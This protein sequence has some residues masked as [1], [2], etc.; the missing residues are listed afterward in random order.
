[1]LTRGTYLIDVR[2]LDAGGSVIDFASMSLRVESEQRIADVTTDADRYRRGETIR[3]TVSIDGTLTR[4]QRVMISVNDMWGRQVHVADAERRKDERFEFRIPVNDPLS[5]LWDVHACI[6]DE[7]G[8]VDR[9]TTPV[10]ILNN[11]FDDF[12]FMLIFAPTPGRSNWKGALHARQLRKYGINAAYVYLIYGQHELYFHN[13]R[14]HLRSV[15]YAEHSG[16]IVTPADNNADLTVENRTYDLAEVSRMVRGIADT[17]EKLD[18][19]EYPYRMG[20]FS[21]DWIN[22]RIENYKL[23]GRFGTPFYTLTGES[24]LLGEFKGMENSGFAPTATKRFQQWC[25]KQSNDDLNAL[26]REWG[27]EL[28]DWNDVRG[29]MLKAAVEQNQLPRWVDFRYF[30]RSQVFSRSR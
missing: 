22:S 25:R 12:L 9:K 27:S 30:M 7:Q 6:V 8:V 29:I 3:G 1:M 10:P 26:N 20:H 24:Y 28:K 15:A 11:T 21:A 18:P 16:E 17:G 2:T 5:E 19:R 23:A 4:G 14:E 13:A